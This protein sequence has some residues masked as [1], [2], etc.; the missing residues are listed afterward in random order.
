MAQ[1][2]RAQVYREKTV[3]KPV[4]PVKRRPSGRAR[5]FAGY[6]GV[7]AVLAFI[8][9]AVFV[10]ASQKALIA[11]GSLE[12]ERLEAS[13][14]QSKEENE[15]LKKERAVLVTPQRIEEVA[16]AKLKMTKPVKV[17]YIKLEPPKDRKNES[18]AMAKEESQGFFSE[19]WKRIGALY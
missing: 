18:V 15:T 19:V 3:R 14:E 7:A 4:R 2:A 5:T 13:F 10:N 8:V 11:Q 12:L 9:G 6:L 17:S 1:V 16:T